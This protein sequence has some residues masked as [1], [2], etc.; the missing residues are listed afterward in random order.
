MQ[1]RRRPQQALII[2]FSSFIFFGCSDFQ[3]QSTT[4]APESNE[5]SQSL[6]YES[7][8]LLSCN[9][10]QRPPLF[11]LPGGCEQFQCVPDGAAQ[12]LPICSVIPQCGPGEVLVSSP[13]GACQEFRCETATIEENAAFVS[14]L[15]SFWLERVPDSEEQNRWS[16]LARSVSR[17]DIQIS[18]LNNA[19]ENDQAFLMD[20]KQTQVKRVF[21]QVDRPYPGW[22]TEA[23]Q[24]APTPTPTPEPQPDPTEENNNPD[25]GNPPSEE[26]P[27][28]APPEN[29]QPE[30]PAGPEPAPGNRPPRGPIALLG[31]PYVG[32]TQIARING[33]SDPDGFAPE[34]GTYQWLRS[35]RAIAGARAQTY[36]A[37]AEDLCEQIQV[38]FQF[39]DNGGTLETVLSTSELIIPKPFES[40]VRIDEEQ[41]A[42][43]GAAVPGNSLP[44]GPLS[45]LGDPYVGEV[46]LARPNGIQDSDGIDYS[47][48]SRP[49][50]F[51]WYRDN[52]PI[53]G[54]TQQSYTLTQA[55]FHKQIRVRLRY[56]DRRG[57]EEIVTSKPKTVIRD[58]VDFCQPR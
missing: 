20:A 47:S 51:Q 18:F 58:P 33:V 31:N 49:G 26:S 55:D 44:R 11:F 15:Y 9:Q 3:S 48:W 29:S 4:S 37:V 8:T 32:E 52:D 13:Q 17:V 41:F 22:L 53:V 57:S 25:A 12:G 40:R 30:T 23:V 19:S 6:C 36:T 14:G 45:I 39:L 2:L 5:A 46:L 7:T 28:P 27:S 1:R 50:D 38:R 54:A 24:P 16:A 42:N 10:A 35:G 21:D 56:R 34:T 43:P